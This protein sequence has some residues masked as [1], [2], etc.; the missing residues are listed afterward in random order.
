LSS[1]L[2][3]ECQAIQRAIGEKIGTICQAF[4]MSTSGLFFAFFKGAYFSALL[5]CYF[6]IMFGMTYFITVAFSQ[7]FT[8]QMKAYG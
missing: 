3:K 6:P 5:L 1:R 8:K 7:G 4:A 2:G